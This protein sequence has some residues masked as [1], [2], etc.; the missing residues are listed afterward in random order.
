M[1]FRYETRFENLFSVNTFIF[2][3]D[4]D[5]NSTLYKMIVSKVKENKFAICRVSLSATMTSVLEET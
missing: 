1:R 2:A 5:F 3:F 4:L